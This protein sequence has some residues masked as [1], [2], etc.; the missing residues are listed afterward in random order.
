MRAAL[1]LLGASILALVVVAALTLRDETTVL[2]SDCSIADCV[3]PQ[4]PGG[5]IVFALVAVLALLMA[6]AEA[7]RR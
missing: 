1:L 7:R 2:V 3:E 6:V 4:G 5:M